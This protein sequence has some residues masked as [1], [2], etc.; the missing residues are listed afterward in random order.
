M[1]KKYRRKDPQVPF[2]IHGI[3]LSDIVKNTYLA[4]MNKAATDRLSE[5]LITIDKHLV[6]L[7]TG[8][9]IKV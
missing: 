8:K 5:D 4:T 3:A 1:P 2:K 6:L 9:L 7:S